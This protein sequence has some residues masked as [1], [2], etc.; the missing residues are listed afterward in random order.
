MIMF[1]QFGTHVLYPLFVSRE[2]R[3]RGWIR[4]NHLCL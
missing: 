2:Y 1:S 4:G 3:S